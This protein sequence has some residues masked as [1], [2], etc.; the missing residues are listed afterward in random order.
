MMNVIING[1]GSTQLYSDIKYNIQPDIF[2]EPILLEAMRDI[3][4]VYKIEGLAFYSEDHGVKSPGDLSNGM[5]ALI[6]CVYYAKGKVDTLISNACMGEN[7]GKYLAQ[8][9]TKYNFSIAWDY[10]MC[11]DWDIPISAREE[12]TGLE[13]KTAGELVNYYY[14]FMWG[15]LCI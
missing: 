9:S 7:C 5:K 15:V 11:F 2:D 4:K 14:N 8:L 12:K 10:P 3:E 1:D 13:F 6:L